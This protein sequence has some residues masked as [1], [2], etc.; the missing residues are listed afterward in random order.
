MG[1]LSSPVSRVVSIAFRYSCV[2]IVISSTAP[3]ML[4]KREKALRM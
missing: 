4:K 3:K 1:I 2:L